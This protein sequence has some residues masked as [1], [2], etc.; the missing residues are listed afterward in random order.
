MWGFQKYLIQL[1]FKSSYSVFVYLRASREKTGNLCRILFLRPAFC[2]RLIC[3]MWDMNK[4]K[5]FFRCFSLKQ[6]LLAATVLFCLLLAS[7]EA[8][9]LDRV[10]FPT[11]L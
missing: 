3:Q 10:T 9:P 4:I 5:G 1:F 11:A 2:R 8:F 6:M 7:K